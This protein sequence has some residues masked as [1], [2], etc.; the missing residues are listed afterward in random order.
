MLGMKTRF[1]SKPRIGESQHAA[2]LP[3]GS[4]DALGRRRDGIALIPKGDPILIAAMLPEHAP[5]IVIAIPFHLFHPTTG[6]IGTAPEDRGMD[7][8][9]LAV[10]RTE[11]EPDL[12]GQE[13]E[14]ESYGGNALQ[15]GRRYEEIRRDTKR[16]EEI[17]RDTKRYEEIRRD[18]KRYEEIRRDTKR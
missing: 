13:D 4:L 8:L 18:T 10:V 17:R 7:G 3:D 11:G 15:R 1:R 9:P 14:E 2:Q 5:T 6:H 12:R 16:Y